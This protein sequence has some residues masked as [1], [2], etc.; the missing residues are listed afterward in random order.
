VALVNT[1][2][3]VVATVVEIEAAAEE[4]V[5]TEAVAID[6][7]AETDVAVITAVVKEDNYFEKQNIGNNVTA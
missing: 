4:A 5:I 2:V 1:K 7:A 3:A 6:A